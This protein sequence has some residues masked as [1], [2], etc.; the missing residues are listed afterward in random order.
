ML[1]LAVVRHDALSNLFLNGEDD[2]LR[3]TLKLKKLADER[4][5]KIVRY[6]GDNLIT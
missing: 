6:V 4:G 5:G 2:A 1:S 3:R